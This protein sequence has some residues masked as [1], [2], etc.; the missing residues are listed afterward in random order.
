MTKIYHFLI[1]NGFP[2]GRNFNFFEKNESRQNPEIVFDQ[3]MKI[4]DKLRTIFVPRK[5]ST[6][7]PPTKL[8]SKPLRPENRRTHFGLPYQDLSRLV[9][10]EIDGLSE[11]AKKRVLHKCAFY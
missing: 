1:K 6:F 2:D 10:P 9:D 8:N 11:I 5:T 7:S 4:F 3:K